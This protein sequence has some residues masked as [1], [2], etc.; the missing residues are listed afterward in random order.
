MPGMNGLDVCARIRKNPAMKN[1]SILMVTADQ[2]NNMGELAFKT[3]ADAF[4]I[5]PLEP[6]NPF[7]NLLTR[8]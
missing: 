8:S 4:L 5:K 2:M 3:G 1:V 6:A 7:S